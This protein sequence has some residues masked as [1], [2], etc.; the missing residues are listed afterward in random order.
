MHTIAKESKRDWLRG[1]GIVVIFI[2]EVD[3]PASSLL[4]RQCQSEMDRKLEGLD[5]RVQN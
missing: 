2:G 4:R 3:F 1:V 5:W